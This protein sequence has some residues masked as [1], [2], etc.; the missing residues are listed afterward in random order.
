MGKYLDLESSIYS[1]FGSQQWKAENIPTYPSNVIKNDSKSSFIR[2]SIIPNSNSVNFKSISGVLIIDIFTETNIGT[3]SY[4]TIADRLDDYLVTKGFN[5]N[6]FFLQFKES[7]LTPMGVDK[8][9]ASLFRAQYTI[10][11]NFF[12]V[13]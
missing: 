12:G 8:D 1:I 5:K 6:N 7:V 3:K 13:D 10:T 4:S 11:F 2:L 9:S